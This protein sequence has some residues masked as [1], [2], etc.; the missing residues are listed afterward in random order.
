MQA[1]CLKTHQSLICVHIDG[2]CKDINSVD[3]LEW[4]SPCDVQLEDFQ[5]AF[6]GLDIDLRGSPEARAELLLRCD[7]LQD[8]LWEVCDHR[9]NDN[10]AQL[11]TLKYVAL[12]PGHAL[13][14]TT[15]CLSTHC[16]SVYSLLP[17]HRCSPP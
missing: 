8:A 3:A 6:N 2:H 9:M 7:E 17:H 1:V 14:S 15:H 10:E 12:L 13:S 11:R 16:K 4:R 5:K